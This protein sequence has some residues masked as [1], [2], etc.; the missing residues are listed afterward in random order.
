M[1]IAEDLAG[2]GFWELGEAKVVRWRDGTSMRTLYLLNQLLPRDYRDASLML[3][4][5]Q[6][7]RL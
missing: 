6:S 4:V 1:R 5:G 3:N 7:V 2:I